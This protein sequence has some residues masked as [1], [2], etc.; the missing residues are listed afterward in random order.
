MELVKAESMGEIFDLQFS[1]YD[2]VG[3]AAGTL[4]HKSSI[5][6]QN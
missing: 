6:N 5:K 3:A 4:N 1:T 2:L